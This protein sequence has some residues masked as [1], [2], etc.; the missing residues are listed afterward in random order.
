MKTQIQKLII[1]LYCACLFLASFTG[2]TTLPRTYKKTSMAAQ[3][4]L[5][6]FAILPGFGLF[7]IEGH[8]M[9]VLIRECIEVFGFTPSMPSQQVLLLETGKFCRG[10]AQRY[11]LPPI[12]MMMGQFLANALRSQGFWLQFKSDKELRTSQAF[13]ASLGDSLCHQFQP[14]AFVEIK[15]KHFIMPLS[16]A[17]ED[18]D[19][20]WIEE[21]LTLVTKYNCETHETITQDWKMFY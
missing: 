15:W 4:L 20:K 5:G 19:S 10:E 3:Q 2:L 14:L 17:N 18:F 9:P 16:K 13:L 11:Y 1:F 21:N 7:D 6:T 12:E 8:D